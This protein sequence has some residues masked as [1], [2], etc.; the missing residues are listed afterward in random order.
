MGIGLTEDAEKILQI[1]EIANRQM[2]DEQYF[3]GFGQNGFRYQRRHCLDNCF[4]R[5]II[6]ANIVAHATQ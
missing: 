4:F 5:F 6:K 1:G 3:F 2:R